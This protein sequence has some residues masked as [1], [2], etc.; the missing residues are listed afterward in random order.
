MRPKETDALEQALNRLYPAQTPPPSFETGWRAAIR[1]EE[2]IQMTHKKPGSAVW[3]AVIP[4]FAALVLVAGSLWAGTLEMPIDRPTDLVTTADTA[5]PRSQSRSAG[6]VQM[7]KTAA[8]DAANDM[9]FSEGEAASYEF[10]AAAPQAAPTETARKLVHTASLTLRTTAFDADAKRVQDLLAEMGGYVENLY[11]YGD[12]Q[13]GSARSLSLSMRIPADQLDA[14]LS[15]AEAISRV[16]DRSE[17]T[18]DMTVQYTDNAARLKTLRDKMARLEQLMAQAENVSDLVEIENAIADTQYQ[19][20]L[21][22]T[23]QR[24]IDR[25]VD[26][27]SV[28]VTL[29]EET[30][31]QSAAREDMSLGARMRA[32][33]EASVKWLGQFLRNMLVFVVMAL[34]VLAPAAVIA[35][36]AWLI[37]R[38]RRKHTAA[39]RE[40][41]ED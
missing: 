31:S 24:D 3:R 41:A 18:T 10:G 32:G 16:T 1:R 11:Q 37:V 27:S 2:S 30:P 35:A 7:A 21:Y 36:V 34:P 22:E 4:A 26:M 15:G 17:S 13:N 19:I 5:A 6:G 9:G 23:S 25:R 40:D 29:V 38:K 14:F 12:P 39:P 8:Y 33:L 28:N 20:D